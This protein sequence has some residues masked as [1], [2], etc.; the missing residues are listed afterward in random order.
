MLEC[1]PNGVM[2]T[3]AEGRVRVVNRALG[4]MLPLVPNSVGRWPIEVVP[5]PELAE[6]MTSGRRDEVE[7]TLTS[8]NLVVVLKRH[9]LLHQVQLGV[10][11]LGRWK[12]PMA[13]E[14]CEPRA[15]Q[16][17]LV[18]FLGHQSGTALYC[19]LVKCL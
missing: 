3:D 16:S 2:S 17:V 11:E 1:S 8:G 18:D 10:G 13:A 15:L 7:F 6:A 9:A 5:N 14:P 19:D 12:E 4:E